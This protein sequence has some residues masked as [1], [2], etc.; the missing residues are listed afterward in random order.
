MTPGPRGILFFSLRKI[1]TEFVF[2]RLKTVTI[3]R[4]V[5]G[6]FLKKTY[7]AM[8]KVTVIRTHSY[9][10]GKGVGNKVHAVNNVR[11]L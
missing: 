1:I 9:R 8:S 11:H 2:S 3:S 10:R 4:A 5:F 7:S 6:W